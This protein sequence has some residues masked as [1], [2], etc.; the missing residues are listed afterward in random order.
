MQCSTCVPVR[1]AYLSLQNDHG[2][3]RNNRAATRKDLRH[4]AALLIAAAGVKL[5]NALN[6]TAEANVTADTVGMQYASGLHFS[7]RASVP[8]LKELARVYEAG[9]SFP[10]S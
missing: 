3:Y 7:G 1:L 8:A 6:V 9:K 5:P 4:A 10:S 2:L